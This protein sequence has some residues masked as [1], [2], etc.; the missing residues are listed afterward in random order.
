MSLLLRRARRAFVGTTALALVLGM[1]AAL[2]AAAQPGDTAAPLLA[3]GSP[4][5][6]PGRYL[7]VLKRPDQGLSPSATPDALT[8]TRSTASANGGSVRRDFT[9]AL[10]GFSADLPPAALDALRRDPAV[11]YVEADQIH[12]QPVRASSQL[13]QANPPWHLDRIDQHTL[14]LDQSYNPP[15]DA[16]GVNVYV[17]DSGVRATH[18]EFEGRATG[19]FTAINDGNGTNDCAD[20]GTFVSSHIAGRTF[21]AAKKAAIKMVRILHCDNTA[22]TEEIVAGM[23]WAAANVPAH[24]VVNMSIES[25]GGLSDQALDDAAAAM[26]DHGLLL[27]LITGNFDKGDCMNSPK[28]PRAITMAATTIGDSR[29]TGPFPS[30]YGPCVTAFA[31][32]ADVTGAGK[33][34][35][36]TVLTGFYGTSFAAPLA[37]A[38]VA[39]ALKNNPTLTLAQAKDLIVSTATTN[40]LTNIGAGSPNR[41]LFA[42]TS[43]TPSQN[44]VVT[45][46]GNQTSTAGTPVTLAIRATDP[47]SDPLTYTATGLP[48]GLTINAGT[49]VISGAPTTAGVSTVTVTAKDPGGN[50]GS[51]SFSW[52]V[53]AATGC[54]PAQLVGNGG[55]ESG[56]TPWTGDTHTIGQ[57]GQAHNGT[58]VASL[59]GYGHAATERVAQTVTIPAGC[60]ATLTYF[61][62]IDT[63]ETGTT[64]FDRMTVKLGGTTLSTFSNLDAKP[65][66]TA[67]TANVSGFAGRTVALEFSGTE[68]SALQTSFTLDDIAITTS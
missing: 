9:A 3:A 47:Q 36:T 63:A 1:A 5:V 50:T 19:V 33:D 17:L 20:H 34:S 64:A 62:H 4:H 44:P 58:R 26:I 60:S 38:T 53:T 57:F 8:R 13:A 37:T 28:D 41:L 15:N 65:G 16:A 21:G 45:N 35:D 59:D 14:P 42:G 18:T 51:A 49:G 32:G 46:P 54:T 2:P 27:V 39:M 66:Y 11:A 43:G 40:V 48:A 68:D 29:N 25:G 52:K 24:S 56:T 6:V 31:P 7:V 22:S 10:R 30:S 12:Q 55:F 61:L 67:R 23:N